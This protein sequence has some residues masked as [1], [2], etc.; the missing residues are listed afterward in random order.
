M[1]AWKSSHGGVNVTVMP[2]LS[3]MFT[4]IYGFHEQSTNLGLASVCTVHLNPF[5]E[6]KGVP[7]LILTRESSPLKGA[8]HVSGTDGST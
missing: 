5:F 1:G 7:A 3:L 8:A 2:Q 4:Q 6:Y